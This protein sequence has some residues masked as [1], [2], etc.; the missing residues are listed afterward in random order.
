MIG[1][2][3]DASMSIVGV[4]ESA[5]RR[6][7]G[8]IV[9]YALGSCV[10]VVLV[11]RARAVAGVL[12]LMLPESRANPDRAAERPSTFADTGVPALLRA[13]VAAGADRRAIVAAIAGGAELLADLDRFRIG[14]RNVAAAK[15]ELCAAGIPLVAEDVGGSRSRTLAVALPNVRI[16]VR[17]SGQES[18]LWSPTT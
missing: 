2:T 8:S 16:T 13:L 18:L 6:G 12:H 1:A 5:V 10:A 9:T 7:A 3:V 11:D 14:A 15:A 17:T 4:A